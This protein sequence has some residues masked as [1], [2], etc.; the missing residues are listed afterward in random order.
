MPNTYVRPSHLVV[1][2]GLALLA[3]GIFTACC[4]PPSPPTPK[5]TECRSGNPPT[6]AQLDACLA[7]F[8]FDTT[9]E[10]GDEQPLTVVS[11]DSGLACPGDS[12]GSLRCR[13][14]PIAKIEPLIGAQKYSD[15]ALREG[16]FIARITMDSTQERYP[17]YNLE[18]GATTYWWVKTDAAGT[19]GVSYFI[20]RMKD[21]SVVR[22]KPRPLY[23]KPYDKSRSGDYDKARARRAIMRWIWDLKDETAKGQCGSATCH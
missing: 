15:E 21:G 1:R 17:K 4:G 5:P 14:G 22:S 19:G 12:T 2:I 6:D 8:D 13:Y 16:R 9:Y 18:P 23:R 11:S 3:G 7:G 20:T 10:A